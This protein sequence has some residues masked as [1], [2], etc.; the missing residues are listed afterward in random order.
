M[1]TR[2]Q[3]FGQKAETIAVRQL[4]K[5]GYKIIT[6]NYRNRIGEI[7]IVARD[8]N[9]LVF[10][11]VKARKNDRYGHPKHAL[12]R[13]KQR[14]VSMVALEYLKSTGQNSAKARFDVVAI[15]SNQDEP[16]IEIV[17]NAFELAYP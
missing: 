3:A 6:R 2:R 15:T 9:T 8:G 4:E 12:T 13:A 7:D 11:E 10:V 1:V 5:A 17:K 16:Q 14:K